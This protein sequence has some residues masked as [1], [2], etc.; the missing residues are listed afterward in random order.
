MTCT[1]AIHAGAEAPNRRI[2][3]EVVIFGKES[4]RQLGDRRPDLED[5]EVETVAEVPSSKPIVA[6]IVNGAP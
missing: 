4:G 2:E 5:A 1:A 6:S 3:I